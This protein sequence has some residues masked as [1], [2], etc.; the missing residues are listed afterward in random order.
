MPDSSQESVLDQIVSDR[1]VVICVGS[2][3][4]GKTTTSAAL[5][6]RAACKG[7]RAIVLTVDPAR[8]LANALGMES[9]PHHPVEVE[10][11]GKVSGRMWALML[12]TRATFDE[13]I[14]RHAPSESARDKILS[15]PFYDK[16][17][18]ML[19]GTHEYMA[20]EQLLMLHESDDYDCIILDTPPSAHAVNFLDAPRRLTAFMNQNTT[21]LFLKATKLMT[22]PLGI[23]GMGGIITRGIS[24]FVGSDF[25]RDLLA[26][27]ESFD[28]MF[29]S[30]DARAQRTQKL[31]RSEETGFVIIHAPEPNTVLEAE[32]FDALLGREKMNID[33]FLANRVHL[34]PLFEKSD[35]WKEIES[36]LKKSAKEL[37]ASESQNIQKLQALH[38]NLEFLARRDSNALKRIQIIT[39]KGGRSVPLLRVPH[40][41]E[42]LHDIKGLYR[43]SKNAAEAYSEES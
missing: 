15:N 9:M 38:E 1:Q 31:L 4:V 36:A 18:S 21:R 25:F 41:N 8:R 13:V 14:R 3:G 11:G 35:A 26:F 43:F 5:A 16:A 19:A 28:G 2:G 20:M 17:T 24:I 30:F 12:D 7:K 34:P 10:L 42:D 40:F 23:F 29:D 33:A 39:K 22:S 27:I 37:G 32:K 6:L